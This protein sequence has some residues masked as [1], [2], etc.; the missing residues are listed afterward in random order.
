MKIMLSEILLTQY[1]YSTSRTCRR[2]LLSFLQ[3]NTLRIKFGY[4]LMVAKVVHTFQTSKYPHSFSVSM[5]F[6][7]ENSFVEK[8]FPLFFVLL[9]I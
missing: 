8:R 4:K 7:D 1:Q 3:L 2:F 6:V 9:S 5:R